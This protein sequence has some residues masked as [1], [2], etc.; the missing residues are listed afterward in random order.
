MSV[1]SNNIRKKALCKFYLSN[2]C[3]KGDACLFSHDFRSLDKTESLSSEEMLT[4]EVRDAISYG[5]LNSIFEKML[6]S[7]EQ[8]EK[9][10]A[11]LYYNFRNVIIYKTKGKSIIKEVID[12]VSLRNVNINGE[13]LAFGYMP[14]LFHFLMMGY[15]W[16]TFYSATDL[17]NFQDINS[18]FD[19]LI[20]QLTKVNVKEDQVSKYNDEEYENMLREAC[21]YVNPFTYEN[22][23]HVAAHYVCESVINHVKDKFK[24]IKRRKLI[25]EFGDDIIVNMRSSMSREEFSSKLSEDFNHMLTIKN[26]DNQNVIDLFNIRKDGKQLTIDKFKY[27]IEKARKSHNES[28]INDNIK[29]QDYNL[30]NLDNKVKIFSEIFEDAIKIIKINNTENYDETFNNNYTKLFRSTPFGIRCEID[31]LDK[32]LYLLNT[33][34]KSKKDEYIKKILDSIP[35]GLSN[36]RDVIKKFTAILKINII[37]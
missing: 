23:I 6:S 3:N 24:Q 4:N 29:R 17:E 14:I 35:A 9:Y 12:T 32:M 15:T 13:I 20:D 28:I 7:K 10:Y 2:K 36:S 25:K 22:F 8:Y 30:A 5:K 34:L 11:K 33:E 18:C 27:K 21:D 31:I 26:K 16:H 19:E 37:L 1:S